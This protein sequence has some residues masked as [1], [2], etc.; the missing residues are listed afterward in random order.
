MAELPNIDF[1]G[2]GGCEHVRMVSNG[3]LEC[4]AEQR[5]LDDEC[6]A[7]QATMLWT[8]GGIA[9]GLI[10][11]VFVVLPFVSNSRCC[12]VGG[13]SDPVFA[14]SEGEVYADGDGDAPC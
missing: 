8:A 9:A 14:R 6:A 1:V 10:F 13:V 3:S 5:E 2:C 7:A 4:S 12:R 11:V